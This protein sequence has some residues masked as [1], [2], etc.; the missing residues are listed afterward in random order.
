M[1]HIV[2]GNAAPK[3]F[4]KPSGQPSPKMTIDIG[5]GGGSKP[6]PYPIAFYSAGR[7]STRVISAV[8]RV[9]SPI[10]QMVPIS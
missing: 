7:W 10:P 9:T 5:L 3:A 8:S 2:S 4:G 6:P 1:F